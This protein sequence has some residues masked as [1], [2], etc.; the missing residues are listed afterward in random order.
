M[1]HESVTYRIPMM[2]RSLTEVAAAAALAG[3]LAI[4]H[5]APA[6]AA[7]NQLLS[8]DADVPAAAGSA[9]L[10]LGSHGQEHARPEPPG[11][12]SVIV[13]SGRAAWR[14]L[15]AMKVSGGGLVHVVSYDVP[16]PVVAGRPVEVCFVF[17]QPGDIGAV[18]A[19]AT[20]DR[21]G[22]VL[23]VSDVTS[24]QDLFQDGFR[25]CITV[26]ST[27]SQPTT[28]NVNARGDLRG[29]SLDLPAGSLPAKA[30]RRYCFHLGNHAYDGPVVVSAAD[31]SASPV[32][33][34]T[35]ATDLEYRINVGWVYCATIGNVTA[36]P[37][38]SITLHIR[39]GLQDQS[40]FYGYVGYLTPGQSG[41][42]CFNAPEY[43][44][45]V[46]AVG[47]ASSPNAILTTVSTD[48]ED[49][50]GYGFVYCATIK[51]SSAVGTGV[52]LDGRDGLAT[53]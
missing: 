8:R 13:R 37:S 25:Y 45:P 53:W 52:T 17:G 18:A 28:F 46:A 21:Y 5:L 39:A 50:V 40:Y 26:T 15:V 7:P 34:A 48:R 38:S 3:L 47:R 16:D 35:L 27:S 30:S 33:L 31:S 9:T 12:A 49:R 14:S 22:V 43:S 44:L 11:T 19:T 32:Q 4:A 36:R 2:I 41:R 20:P 42:Y 29:D 51:N 24:G 6:V 23:A 1:S 10:S